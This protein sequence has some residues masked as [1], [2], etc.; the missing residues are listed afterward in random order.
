[1]KRRT[2]T[3]P[4]VERVRRAREAFARRCDYDLDKM[5]EVLKAMQ[6]KHPQRV[7]DLRKKRPSRRIRVQA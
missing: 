6:A 5:F 2:E 1:M 7:R 3:N 4:T